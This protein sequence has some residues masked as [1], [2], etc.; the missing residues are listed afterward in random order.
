MKL[1]KARKVGI[2]SNRKPL[3]ISPCPV[4]PLYCAYALQRRSYASC[5]AVRGKAPHTHQSLQRSASQLLRL[6]QL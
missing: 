1:G 5:V 4:R 3:S 2:G 6:A